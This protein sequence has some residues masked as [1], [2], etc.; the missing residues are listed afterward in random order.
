MKTKSVITPGAADQAAVDR[1]SRRYF[2]GMGIDPGLYDL[3]R[4]TSPKRIYVLSREEIARF[5]LETRNEIYETQWATIT[6][7]NQSLLVT[8]SVTRRSL[9]EPTEYLTMQFQFSCQFDGQAFLLYRRQPARETTL[10]KSVINVAF[11]ARTLAFRPGFPEERMETGYYF[12]RDAEAWTNVATAQT[13]TVIERKA[14]DEAPLETKLS[15]AGLEAALEEFQKH[16][17]QRAPKSVKTIPM[18]RDNA[19]VKVLQARPGEWPASGTAPSPS[20]FGGGLLRVNPDCW[21]F[22]PPKAC[23]TRQ[24]P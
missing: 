8:K 5:G 2:V 13:I 3:A 19:P 21:K 18:K 14:G 10:F 17:V 6:A 11:D 15:T 4:K 9:S 23:D 16:C 7:P 12:L 24:N 1:V 20:G 22:A